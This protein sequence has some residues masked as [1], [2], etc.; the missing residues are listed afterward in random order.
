MEPRHYGEIKVPGLRGLRATA[1]YFHDGSAA[2]IEDVV[3]HY[4]ELDE[5]RLHADGAR[6]LQA[7]KLKPP[8]VADLATFLETLSAPATVAKGNSARQ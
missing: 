4:S 2:T 8:Q 7:L 1:A 6:L 3:R 5:S